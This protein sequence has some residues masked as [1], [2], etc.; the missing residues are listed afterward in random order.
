MRVA[1]KFAGYSL[2]EADN[3]RKACGKKK[4]ELMAIERDEVRRRLRGAPATARA[5]GTEL[6]DVIEALRRLRLRQVRT[7]F[8]YGLIAYQTAYLKAHHPV[9]YLAALLTSVKANLD[10]AAVY[11]AECRTMGIPVLVPDVNRSAADFVAGP[12]RRRPGGHPVRPV[13]GAQRRQRAG[14]PASWP[15]ARRTGPFTSFYRLL[16]PGAAARCSTRRRSRRS[17]RPARSTRSA[18]RAAGLLAVFESIV[19]R[20]VGRR[21]EADMGV[22]TL[23]GDA[24]R[25][26]Q[27]LRRP[28]R[29]SPTCSSRRP[30][31]SASRRRCSA[32]T[33]ATTR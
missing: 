6:F 26:R 24:R 3:L 11:L 15:S 17:S 16:R 5:L 2:A 9:E 7:R 13:G 21:R 20:T 14:R 8:G 18:T 4:R 32:S 29:P 33:S 10:K 28:A 22:M 1:Q 23:F 31:S 27:R 30:T 19:D 12:P 25:G